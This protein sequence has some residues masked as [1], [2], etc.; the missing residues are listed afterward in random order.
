MTSKAKK[1]GELP[2]VGS[3]NLRQ[4]LASS[5]IQGL[6]AKGYNTDDLPAVAKAAVDLADAMVVELSKEIKDV[7]GF[8]EYC[9][10]YFKIT[11]NETLFGQNGDP[12]CPSCIL[13]FQE[14]RDR[15]D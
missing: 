8:C 4:Y 3:L 15:A 6:A 5:V 10:E 14:D 9:L 2:A 11:G 13:E 7:Y 12:Y 1:Y